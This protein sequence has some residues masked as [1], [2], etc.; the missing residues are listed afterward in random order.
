MMLNQEAHRLAGRIGPGP[1]ETVIVETRF[2]T[3]EFTPASTIVMPQ[4]L[5]GFAEQQLFGLANLPDPVPEDFKLL[6]SLGEPPISF[7]VMPISP[8]AAPIEPADRDE[9]FATLG[10][11]PE[12]SVFLFIC[13]IRPKQDGQGIDMWANLRA[14]IVF[15]YG[16]EQPV[17]DAPPARRLE[18]QPVNRRQQR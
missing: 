13:T 18:R 7:I 17:L 14:P 3:Y 11:N 1:E 5:V 9:A 15:D 8:E 4:G 6:Q 2:G 16:F 12:E 10:G